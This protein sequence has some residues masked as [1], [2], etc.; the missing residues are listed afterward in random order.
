MSVFEEKK[1]KQTK[2]NKEKNGTYYIMFK[3]DYSM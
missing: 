1:E 2:K 3:M